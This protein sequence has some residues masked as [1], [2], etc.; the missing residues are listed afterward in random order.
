MCWGKLYFT[1][2]IN[3]LAG[4]KGWTEHARD[5]CECCEGRGD[6]PA[7]G[8]QGLELQS[9]WSPGDLGQVSELPALFQVSYTESPFPRNMNLG[10]LTT[11]PVPSLAQE[12]RHL[13]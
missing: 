12:C 11:S 3:L 6:G 8:T 10:A 5:V 1:V 7:H 2:S 13:R 4:Q 9:V